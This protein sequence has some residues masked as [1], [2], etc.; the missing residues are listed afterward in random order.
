[1]PSLQEIH[2]Q[3]YSD[4]PFDQ[5][6]QKFHD[7]FYSD[8]PFEAF[9]AKAGG[10]PQRSTQQI[11]GD[12]AKNAIAPVAN[13]PSTYS[14][15]VNQSVDQMKQ[16]AGRVATGIDQAREGNYLQAL[17]DVGAGAGNALLGAAGYV[18]AP[19]N[20]PVH[21][22]IGQPV[23]KNVEAATGSKTAGELA[24]NVADIGATFAIPLPKR[25]PN[26]GAPSEIAAASER[27]GVPIPMAAATDSIPA[28]ASAGAVAQIPVVGAPLVK[29]SKEATAGMD[30]AARNIAA[31]YGEAERFAAGTSAK[32]GI[33]DW[34]TG[35]STQVADRLYKA[36]DQLV[37]PNVAAPLTE[38]QKAVAGI[39][40]ERKAA[41]LSGNG[42]AADIVS[43]AVQPG[44]QLTY[45][46]VKRLRTTVGEA[47]DSGIVPEGMSKGDLKRIYG[48]LTD[49]LRNTVQQAGGQPALDA[50]EKANSINSQ[51][52]AR[53]QALAKIVGTD[54]N[55]A[56]EMVLDRVIGMASAAR[57]GDLAKLSQARK[58]IGADGWNDVAAAA[59]DK[60][61][62]ATP[63][64]DFSGER[65]LT[66]WDKLSPAGKQ[67]LFNS[68]GKGNLV[69][70]LDDLATLSKAHKSLMEYGNPS[71]T[72]RAVTFGGMAAS[73]WANPIA[74]L[75]GAIG[76]NVLARVFASPV[77]T[78][79]ATKWAIAFDKANQAPSPARAAALASASRNL[80]NNLADIG[81]SVPNVRSLAGQ[82]PAKADQPEQ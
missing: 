42:K 4:M 67:M 32:E 55:A 77:A 27:L 38:T 51:I 60:L 33:A 40:A 81:I 75:S 63:E 76:G 79:S 34:I 59:V 19:I 26:V 21:A 74:T 64:A 31:G 50:F 52:S 37:N 39:Q 7:K 73:A 80:V 25:V 6:A 5:F 29:A 48:A 24:G 18:G 1:M 17:K 54:G 44:A 8:M 11:A 70:S 56:P 15:M 9:M 46:G 62:R 23:A 30:N 43:E 10:A 49:D 13:I 61:G 65:F 14:E 41:F 16:G 68:T 72:G 12:L 47:M 58:A 57:G 69:Q 28:K 78:S 20:A 45:D 22:L 36:V 82:A 2:Q 71:G 3:S 66:A 53:R 35:K